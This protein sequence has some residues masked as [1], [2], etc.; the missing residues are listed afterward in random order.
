LSALAVSAPEICE[1]DLNPL[2]GTEN[3]VVAVDARV[4]IEK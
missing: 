2:M 3:S 1:L 4:R